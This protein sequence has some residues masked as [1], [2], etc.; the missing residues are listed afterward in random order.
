[1]VPPRRW[2]DQLGGIYWLPRLTDKARSALDGKLGGYLYGQSP[3]DKG[4][5]AQ[6]GLSHRDFAVIV[7]NAADDDAVLAA[8]SARD[9]EA[10]ARARTWS[11]ELPARHK[12]FL[13]LMDLDDGYVGNAR[14]I[15]NVFTNAFTALVKRVLPSHA[16][17]RARED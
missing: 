11:D 4:L 12:A 3:M 10:L 17:E 8:L 14:R 5:L 9:P 2:S 1:M 16:I 15:S 7:K 13:R 6:L